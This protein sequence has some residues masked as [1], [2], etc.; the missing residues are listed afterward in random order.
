M[1]LPESNCPELT[2]KTAN[3]ID[4]AGLRQ[5]FVST[6][7]NNLD[8]CVKSALQQD[9]HL[10][11]NSSFDSLQTCLGST[12]TTIIDGCHFHGYHQVSTFLGRF[13][14]YFNVE[15]ENFNQNQIDRK[16]KFP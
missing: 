6:Q 9:F 10:N 3:I 8:L 11:A 1:D 14:K 16:V 13:L 15:L 12:S 2:E 4:D 7:M 5:L